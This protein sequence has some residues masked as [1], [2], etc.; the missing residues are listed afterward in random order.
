MA[1]RPQNVLSICTGGGALDLAFE[2]A[3]P[4]ARTV[5]MVEREAFAVA[6]LVDKMQ[7]GQLDECPVWTDVTTFRGRPWRGV[8]DWLIGGIPCQPHS[9]A[10]KRG[11]STDRRDLWSATRRIIVQCRPRGVVIENVEGMLS[12]GADQ[13]PGAY[14]VINDLAALGYIAEI[15]LFS[16]AEVGFTHRRNRVVIVAYASGAGSQ[17]VGNGD[18]PGRREAAQRHARLGSGAVLAHTTG[19]RCGEARRNWQ[20]SEKRDS[21]ASPALVNA[22][23]W[24]RAGRPQGAVG[25]SFKRAVTERPINRAGLPMSP[26]GP[27]DIEGWQAVLERSPEFE[28]AVRRMADG[29]AGR[30]DRLRMCGNGVH[31]LALGYGIRVGLHALAKKGFPTNEFLVMEN[32]A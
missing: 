19:K 3:V 12:A 13:I 31:P 30:V 1:L 2:L 5:C 32:A 18:N 15:G 6:H 25:R 24:G 10:G 22:S 4:T 26:P 27:G 21:G 7:A 29:L 17:R 23:S 14:R 11:G 28:P 9:Q 8:V 16:A 20:R